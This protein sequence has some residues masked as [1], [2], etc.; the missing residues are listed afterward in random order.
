MDSLGVVETFLHAT[1]L[2]GNPTRVAESRFLDWTVNGEALRT[3][4]GWANPPDDSTNL[5]SGWDLET[6]L[7]WLDGLA[8]SSAGEFPDGRAAILICQ[9]CGD[10]ECGALSTRVTRDE[11]TVSWSDFGWQTP[12][13]PGFVPLEVSLSYAF[14]EAEYDGLLASLKARLVASAVT[15]PAVRRLWRRSEQRTLIQL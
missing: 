3:K 15:V 6:A 8:R 13:V 2:G 7:E 9:L 1:M 11:G 14:A 12:R 5:V 10:L 4:L